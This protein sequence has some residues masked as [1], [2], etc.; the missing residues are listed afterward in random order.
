MND[1][2]FAY[3][4]EDPYVEELCY[5]SDYKSLLIIGS[6]G[7]TLFHLLSKF[8]NNNIHIDCIDININQI[9]LIKNKLLNMKNNELIYYNGIFDN[10]L[11]NAINSNNWNKYFNN[12]I[13]IEYFTDNAVKYTSKSFI[14]HFEYVTSLMDKNTYFYNMLKYKKYDFNNK[15]YPEY[16]NNIDTIINNI[17][18][19]TFYNNNLI[20]FLNN[21][22]NTYDFISLSNISDW[23]SNDNYINL[24]NIVENKLNKNGVIIMRRL[25]SNN[26]IKP[27][28]NLILNNFNDKTN[29]YSQCVSLTK[30]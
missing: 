10:L 2:K 28:N 4:W 27:Y 30:V 5:K 3:Q 25:L 29:F 8:G 16:F 12:D 18:K 22:N 1:I 9:E 14:K 15:L 11:Y 21:T 19:I 24:L 7:E 13:L 17:D 26:I 23:I 6:G 20:D